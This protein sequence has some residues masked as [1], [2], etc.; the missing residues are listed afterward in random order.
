[1]PCNERAKEWVCVG[2]AFAF[3]KIDAK[4]DYGGTPVKDPGGQ[5]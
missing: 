2:M 5:E 1:V 3:C 4:T